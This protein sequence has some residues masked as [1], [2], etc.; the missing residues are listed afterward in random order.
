[1]GVVLICH[2]S[3]LETS[4][5]MH[6]EFGRKLFRSKRRLLFQY[7]SSVSLGRNLD[8]QE[9][10]AWYFGS[11]TDGLLFFWLF[12]CSVLGAH[13]AVLKT[14]S[15]LSTQRLCLEG[16]GNLAM[17]QASS[18]G[19]PCARQ[20][21]YLLSY[22]SGR[23]LPFLFEFSLPALTLCAAELITLKLPNH[24]QTPAFL[25]LLT[26]PVLLILVVLKDI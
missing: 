23:A 3:Q 21:P 26:F 25:L 14:N 12:V 13:P 7:D 15:Q 18:S 4:T 20:A 5:Q 1:M 16:L 22:G 19:Q 11:K 24:L 2:S 9:P 6:S 8:S 17:Y 10:S